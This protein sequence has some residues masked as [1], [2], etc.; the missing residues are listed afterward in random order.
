MN[1]IF[2]SLQVGINKVVITFLLVQ[3]S[4]SYSQN[5]QLIPDSCTFCYHLATD[6]VG[7]HTLHNYELDPSSQMT[8]DSIDYMGPTL[9]QLGFRQFGNKL[10][11]RSTSFQ[12]DELV[13]DF[14]A[15]IGD[16][17]FNLFSE[18]VHYN[19]VVTNKDSVILNGTEY[20]HF[21]ELSGF[22]Y[23]IVGDSLWSQENWTIVWNERGVCGANYS[24]F[25]QGGGFFL[26]HL[27]HGF[28]VFRE[29]ITIQD[30]VLLTLVWVVLQMFLV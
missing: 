3:S 26:I 19:S 10:Y 28:K 25:T 21:M 6:G 20:H 27:I 17:V 30:I 23:R 7:N 1:R 5:Y 12:S 15:Q 2:Y 14:D 18:G 13:M 16:T 4:N 29:F 24:G 8:I 11:A 9:F 22:E